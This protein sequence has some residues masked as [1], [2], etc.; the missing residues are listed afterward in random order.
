LVVSVMAA[1]NSFGSSVLADPRGD[2]AEFLIEVV[3]RAGIGWYSAGMEGEHVA[4][5]GGQMQGLEGVERGLLE[6][7]VDAE[8]GGA[9]QA[10]VAQFGD[11]GVA[12]EAF[13]A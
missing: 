1:A 13:C 7:P 3:A 5:V 10:A 12:L 8:V 6:H 11:A 2:R 9:A 4:V